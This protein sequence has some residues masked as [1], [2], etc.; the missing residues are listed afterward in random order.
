M[1][2]ID[3]IEV[4]FYN[5]LSDEGYLTSNI[6]FY[7]YYEDGDPDEWNALGRFF[8]AQNSFPDPEE[9]FYEEHEEDDLSDE[10]LSAMRAGEEILEWLDEDSPKE[11]EKGNGFGGFFGH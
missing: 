3:D 5:R 9:D 6:D 8:I 7:E 11:P 2:S 10:D 1:K 4:D